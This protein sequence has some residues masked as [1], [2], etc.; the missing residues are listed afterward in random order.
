MLYLFVCLAE[1]L[2]KLSGIFGFGLLITFI[3]SVVAIIATVGFYVEEDEIGFKKLKNVAKIPIT[4]FIVCL[5]GHML[6]SKATV[7]QM[8]GIYLGK[9][10]VNS[11]QLD[12]KLE[13]VSK[14]IDLELN[15]RINEL[16]KG[17]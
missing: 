13:K 11:V 10:T 12:A 6:P 1:L 7:Y 17:E 9:K 5:L 16:E 14:I 15:K 2:D 4:L 3:A 8:A